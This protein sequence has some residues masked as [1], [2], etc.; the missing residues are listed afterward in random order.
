M[1]LQGQQGGHSWGQLCGQ[2]ATD[3]PSAGVASGC[4]VS[5]IPM[6]HSATAGAPRWSSR[7]FFDVSSESYLFYFIVY[8]LFPFHFC[9]LLSR[10]LSDFL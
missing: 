4:L 8:V 6:S 5:V 7:L 2:E 10:Q 1:L 9:G 3:H